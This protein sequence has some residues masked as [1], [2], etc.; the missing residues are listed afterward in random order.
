MHD[1]QTIIKQNKSKAIK[2]IDRTKLDGGVSFNNKLEVLHLSIGYTVSIHS[3]IETEDIQEI[4]KQLNKLPYFTGYFY[5]LWLNKG[6][7]Y[8]DINTNINDRKEA[9]KT[10]KLHKQISIFNESLKKEVKI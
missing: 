10:G 2:L 7:Y 1:L 3:V 8:L 9:I 4:E 5:G 6:I